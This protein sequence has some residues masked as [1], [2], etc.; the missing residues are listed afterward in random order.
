[1]L[2]FG[3]AFYC[4]FL[5]VQQGCKFIFIHSPT[6]THLKVNRTQFA[7]LSFCVET[8]P[9]PLYSCVTLHSRM[10]CSYELVPGDG[11]LDGLHSFAITAGAA[12]K[13]PVCTSFYVFTWNLLNA[14]NRPSPVWPNDP[15][16]IREQTW[17]IP[18]QR[19][20][21]PCSHLGAVA[22]IYMILSIYLSIYLSSI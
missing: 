13:S 22:G 12:V 1:M 21:R 7:F 5:K 11:R 4:F 6:H 14:I 15:R 17:P 19:D 8:F 10:V 20:G 2:A 9:I 16:E 3:Y 18:A